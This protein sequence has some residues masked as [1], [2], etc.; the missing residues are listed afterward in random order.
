MINVGVAFLQALQPVKPAPSCGKDNQVAT[1]IDSFQ[2]LLE[3]LA[4]SLQKYA[5]DSPKSL[6]IHGPMLRC[7]SKSDIVQIEE[8]VTDA[9]Q[10]LQAWLSF[11]GVDDDQKTEELNQLVDE[12]REKLNDGKEMESR[13]EELSTNGLMQELLQYLATQLDLTFTMQRPRLQHVQTKAN[14]PNDLVV[15]K[16]LETITAKADD[17]LAQ[18]NTRQDLQKAAPKLLKLLE[19]TINLRQTASQPIKR[20]DGQ[21]TSNRKVWQELVQAFEKRQRFVARGQYNRHATVTSADVAKWLQHILKRPLQPLEQIGK[22][23]ASSMPMSKIEQ[24]VI[25]VS[26][27]ETT[28]P[29]HQSFMKQFQQAIKTSRFMVMNN[30]TSQ[31]SIALKPES[32]GEMMVRL[33]QN[34]GEMTVKIAVT[35]QAAKEML[36]ANMHQLKHLFSPHQ[37]VIEREELQATSS[38]PL[39][40]EQEDQ[41]AKDSRDDQSEHADDHDEEADEQDD[42]EMHFQDLLMNAKV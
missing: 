9:K 22:Q 16:Q 4:Q 5:L 19:Q 2:Q 36:E 3:A 38:Q 33:V 8:D 25:H 15:L 23:S 7:V 30:G 6:P 1:D 17:I 24:F 20:F 12:V 18:I 35:T 13:F 28:H 14:G 26:R 37:I 42:F 21:Q 34:N 40:T 31:L 39:G 41:L 29:T 11:L 32:L 27:D 10:F